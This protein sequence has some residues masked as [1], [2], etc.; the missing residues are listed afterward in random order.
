M[1]TGE[2][3]ADGSRRR[4]LACAALLASLAAG[5]AGSTLVETPPAAALAAPTQATEAPPPR[6][7][8]ST[9]PAAL[10]PLD[11]LGG[12]EL[13]RRLGEPD[14]RRREPPAEIWQYR[15]S[16]CVLDVFLYREG[17]EP[18]VVYAEARPRGGVGGS[19]ESCLAALAERSRRRSTGL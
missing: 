17:G 16:T 9:R 8:A 2:R 14:F 7:L 6:L 10:A 11:G 12:A 18:R 3:G 5:C 1:R 15:G 19:A 4:A 13:A